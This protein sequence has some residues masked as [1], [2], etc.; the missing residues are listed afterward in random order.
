MLAGYLYFYKPIWFVYAL[1]RAK[2]RV[3]MEPAGMQIIGMMG[4]AITIG[5]TSAWAVRLMFGKIVRLMS[6]F[7]NKPPLLLR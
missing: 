4:L 3:S 2:T 6:C 5:R 7:S 1:L